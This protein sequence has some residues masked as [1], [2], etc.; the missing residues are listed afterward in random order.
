MTHLVGDGDVDA[1]FSDVTASVDLFNE[2][3]LCIFPNALSH[4][5]VDACR[6]C[7]EQRM[8][9]LDAQLLKRGVDLNS[10]WR[11]NEACRRR[12]GRYDVR[13]WALQDRP[14]QD[15]ALWTEAAWLPFVRA[16]LGDDCRELWRGVVDNRPGSETQGWHRDGDFLFSSGF[17]LPVHCITLFIPLVDCLDSCLGPPQ[18]YPG[19]HRASRDHLYTG[20]EEQTCH[21]PY[22]TPSLA[23][24]DL[25][26]FDYRLVHR[27]SAN[28]SAATSRPMLCTDR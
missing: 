12:Y 1:S 10:Q 24:G 25:L 23:R 18:F 8:G 14:F 5:H 22:V 28:M 9:K 27:G 3:G 6:T 13:N 26:A 20:V 21:L 2:A 4:A 7:L 16:A 17:E 11:F 15:A 19:S